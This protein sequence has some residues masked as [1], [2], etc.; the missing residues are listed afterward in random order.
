MMRGQ[1]PKYFFLEPPLVITKTKTWLLTYVSYPCTLTLCMHYAGIYYAPMYDQLQEY[2]DFIETLPL[3]DA[4][5]IFGMH[6]NANIAFQVFIELYASP[7][8]EQNSLSVNSFKNKYDKHWRNQELMHIWKTEITETGS[9][10][11]VFQSR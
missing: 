7:G 8:L 4:P 1:A 6:D 5:E 3:I 9:R 2:R 10:S 11:E